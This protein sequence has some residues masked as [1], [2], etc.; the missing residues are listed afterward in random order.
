[1]KEVGGEDNM[2]VQEKSLKA[3]EA[4]LEHVRKNLSLIA[5]GKEVEEVVDRA[6]TPRKRRAG[7]SDQPPS[8]TMA[9]MVAK[10]TVKMDK[11]MPDDIPRYE[12]GD[13][14]VTV[15]GHSPL[16]RPV[17][18]RWSSSPIGLGYRR[19][20]STHPLNALQ[21]AALRAAI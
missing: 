1:M 17:A 6:L 4:E 8:K 9:Q 2:V 5:E 20:A 21:M 14:Y 19:Y 7:Q 10:K 13:T 16:S 3:I 11:E 12:K 15:L 18:W